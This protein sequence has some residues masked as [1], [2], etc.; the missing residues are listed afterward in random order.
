MN[1]SELPDLL[2]DDFMPGGLLN[3]P[4]RTSGKQATFLGQPRFDKQ[5]SLFGKSEVKLLAR[6][7]ITIGVINFTMAMDKIGRRSIF[8][9]SLIIF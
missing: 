9:I 6:K 5:H 8:K 3:S 7:R 2:T 4:E 1:V